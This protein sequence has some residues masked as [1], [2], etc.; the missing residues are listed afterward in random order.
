[1][2]VRF[3][4]FVTLL[5]LISAY[6]GWQVYS[7]Q[8][9]VVELPRTSSRE[10]V[11]PVDRAATLAHRPVE[12]PAANSAQQPSDDVAAKPAQPPVGNIGPKP[13]QPPIG[14]TVPTPTQRPPNNTVP[15]PAPRPPIRPQVQVPPR[16]NA[17][18]QRIEASKGNLKK[19]ALILQNY[20]AA[21]RRYPTA[22]AD[23]VPKYAGAIPLEPCTNQPYFYIP[24]DTPPT[25]YILTTG[26]YPTDN[27]CRSIVVGIS[28]TPEI[29]MTDSP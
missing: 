26:R 11:E 27:Q 21:N 1:M 24:V 25:G 5:V 13:A 20:F 15:K 10:D 17:A 7:L 22:L 18:K 28:Y 2:P 19:I 23:L 3:L 29:G 6:Y 12:D 8:Q 9:P 16:D 4:A 14:N